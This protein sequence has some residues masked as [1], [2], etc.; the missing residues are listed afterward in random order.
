V[1]TPTVL[2]CT[3]SPPSDVELPL[4]VRSDPEQE[5]AAVLLRL[6]WERLAPW[7]GVWGRRA[8]LQEADVEDVLQQAV[9]AALPN[10]LRQ[11]RPPA[12]DAAVAAALEAYLSAAARHLVA[13]RRHQQ[14]QARRHCSC[15]GDLP[16]RPLEGEIQAGGRTPRPAAEAPS[17]SLEAEELARRVRAVLEQLPDIDRQICLGIEDGLSLRQIAERQD[18]SLEM[19]KGRWR[20]V[21]PFLRAALIG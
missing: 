13:N 9:L 19:I 4:L 11:F 14:Q 15:C 8:R 16:D 3:C 6:F 12:D 5:N 7:V 21:K 17:R 18:V 1:E 10:A 2:E 20:R